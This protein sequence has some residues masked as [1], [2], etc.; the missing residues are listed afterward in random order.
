MPKPEKGTPKWIANQWKKKGLS[1]LRW[2]CGLCGVWCKD[3]NGFKMHLEHP[4][5]LARAIEQEKTEDERSDHVEARY[6]P[7]EYSEAFERSF[8]RYLATH[9]LGERVK[10]H[11]AYRVLNPDDR[12]HA[13]MKRTCWGTLGRFVADLRE[14]GEVW[15]DREGNGWVLSV[16]EDDPAAEWAALPDS[17]ARELRGKV[18]GQKRAWNQVEDELKRKRRRDDGLSDVMRRAEAVGRVD[19]PEATTLQSD[20]KVAFSFG[21]APAVSNDSWA[22]PGLIVKARAGK[23]DFGGA[24][25]VLEI[26]GAG[27]LDQ[28]MMA[29]N[30]NG[31]LA[32]IGLLEGVEAKINV[33]QFFVKQIRMNGI[34]VGS[35]EDFEDMNKCIA[36]HRIKPVVN[37]VF[38][39]SQSN[40]AFELMESGNFIGQI[41]I[42]LNGNNSS[43]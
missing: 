30:N 22:R 39:F 40:K 14:R 28:A 41:V 34:S 23:K 12:P 37:A 36:E 31:S 25:H 32:V 1:K 3:A 43:L 21:G 26:G 7:D 35:R 16:T 24:D 5:H 18:P 29:L 27:T 42:S 38:P 11:E 8:L 4:N 9:R 13:N 15:A 19:A 33:V 10:A 6:C 17:E 2:H 20:V